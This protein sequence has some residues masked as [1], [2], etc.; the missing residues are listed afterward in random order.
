MESNEIIELDKIKIIGLYKKIKEK[1]STEKMQKLINQQ[2]IYG[3]TI[4]MHLLSNKHLFLAK[5]ILKEFKEEYDF[6]KYNI[7]GN[8]ILHC[9]FQNPE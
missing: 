2:D 8:T 5:E 9:L 4:I 7:A 6:T 3:N 1:Y